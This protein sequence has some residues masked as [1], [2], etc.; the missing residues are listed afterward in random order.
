MLD[1]CHPA[2]GHVWDK[3]RRYGSLLHIAR[4]GCVENP[5]STH[6][7]RDFPF[8]P[9]HGERGP[10]LEKDMGRDSHRVRTEKGFSVQHGRRPACHAGRR[11]R[12]RAARSKTG[13]ARTDQRSLFD[14]SGVPHVHRCADGHATRPHGGDR[15][16][17]L[18]P[19]RAG[20]LGPARAG[21]LGPARAGILGPA[22][23][24]PCRWAMPT[25]LFWDVAPFIHAMIGP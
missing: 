17:I 3:P 12:G 7:P 5:F 2:A 19:A 1:N 8:S 10:S 11:S 4:S 22:R 23:Y 16:G 25:L 13:Q 14:T 9:T 20:I 18:G 21:I 6:P 24:R 15:E